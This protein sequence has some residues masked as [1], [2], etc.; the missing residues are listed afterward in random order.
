MTA[1]L[2]VLAGVV[3]LV[4]GWAVARRYF[5]IEY[6]AKPLTLALLTAATLSSDLPV[7]KPWLVAALLLGLVGDIALMRSHDDDGLDAAHRA[8]LLGEGAVA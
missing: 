6:M 3:A 1:A 5:R 8:Q 2:F 4:D 7:L